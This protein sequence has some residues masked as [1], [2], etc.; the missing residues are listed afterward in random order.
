[1]MTKAELAPVK[2]SPKRTPQ[3]KKKVTLDDLINND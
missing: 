2:A 1:M 3:T